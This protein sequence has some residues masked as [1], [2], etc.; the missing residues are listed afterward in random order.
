MIGNFLLRASKNSVHLHGTFRSNYRIDGVLFWP[1]LIWCT[2]P[3]KHIIL[4]HLQ[5]ILHKLWGIKDPIFS[6]VSFDI[7]SL[8]LSLYIKGDFFLGSFSRIYSHL[9]LDTNIT[10][11]M[12]NKITSNLE[13][14]IWIWLELCVVEP[15]WSQ[16][17]IENITVFLF[18][19]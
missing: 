15:T 18:I 16:Q 6:M 8:T 9:V 3:T 4:I 1:I 5:Q 7:H 19:W 11:G 14:L 13:H 12:I 10:T 17:D 2:I